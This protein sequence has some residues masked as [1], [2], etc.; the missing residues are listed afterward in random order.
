MT[1]IPTLSK[2]V[3]ISC[4]MLFAA[5]WFMTFSGLYHGGFTYWL[6]L[7]PLLSVVGLGMMLLVSGR[8]ILGEGDMFSEGSTAQK[9]W[10]F[11]ALGVTLAG[12]GGSLAHYLINHTELPEQWPAVLLPVGA[13]LIAFRYFHY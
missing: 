6:V 12:A 5:G 2:I 10:L 13:G 7:L 3:V 11:L 9:A 4:G 1:A 8:T